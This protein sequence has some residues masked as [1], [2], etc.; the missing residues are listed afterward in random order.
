MSKSI[1]E[2]RRTA[3]HDLRIPVRLRQ[4]ETK[5]YQKA[6]LH[7]INHVGFYVITSHRLTIDQSIEIV[8]PTEL[9]EEMVKIRVKVIRIG[10]HRSWGVFSYGCRIL[11]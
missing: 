4:G 11:L 1:S 10:S 2:C 6:L 9:D 8:V 3:R 5:G 7:N